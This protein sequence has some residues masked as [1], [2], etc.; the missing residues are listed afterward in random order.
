MEQLVEEEVCIGIRDCCQHDS[1]E[2]VCS[3]GET[4]YV[5]ETPNQSYPGVVSSMEE[6]KGEG[7]QAVL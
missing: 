7:G 1:Y 5:R 2:C 6:E 4:A 3:A